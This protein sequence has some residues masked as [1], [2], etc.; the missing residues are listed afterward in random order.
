MGCFVVLTPK[1]FSRPKQSLSEAQFDR[2]GVLLESQAA[3]VH[4]SCISLRNCAAKTWPV[5]KALGIGP[6][7]LKASANFSSCCLVSLLRRQSLTSP[8]ASSLRSLSSAWSREGAARVP[9][10]MKHEAKVVSTVVSKVSVGTPGVLTASNHHVWRKSAQTLFY[11]FFFLSCI[12]L[13]YPVFSCFTAF[14][15]LCS[16]FHF[17][18]VPHF[19][20]ACSKYRYDHLMLLKKISATSP[21]ISCVCWGCISFKTARSSLQCQW[22]FSSSKLSACDCLAW[23]NAQKSD[24]LHRPR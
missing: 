8:Q 15:L 1:N 17:C 9:P 2:V 11:L 24:I 21:W 20:W 16:R 18:L 4:W 10:A 3:N 23:A 6:T 19:A 12:I 14:V 22:M 7:F 13:Y 5:A